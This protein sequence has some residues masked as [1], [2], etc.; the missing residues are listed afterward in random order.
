MLLTN[1]RVIVMTAGPTNTFIAGHLVPSSPTPITLRMDNRLSLRLY[2][3]CLPNFLEVAPLHK[4][5]VLMLDGKELIEEGMGFGV[6]VVKYRDK[7]FFSSSAK[8]YIEG[9][10][11]NCMLVKSFNLDTISRKRLWKTSFVNDEFYGFFQK[12]FQKA[13]LDHKSLSPIFNRIMELGKIMMVET[14][15]IKVKP[16]GTITLRYS[17]Q[18]GIIQIQ[19][20]LSELE[21][22]E[23]Q[24]ILILN[25]QG[26]SF[27]NRYLDT[28]GLSLLNEKIGAWEKVKAKEASLS[29]IEK[30]LEFT[31]RNRDQGFL[32]RGRENTK[33]RFS[34]AGLSYS[35]EPK[36]SLFDYSIRL[37]VTGQ[38]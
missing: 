24:E 5:L 4:G 26:A 25:E 35:L 8:C 14:E 6:P 33:N 21:L 23:C 17:C 28:D 34:W 1:A 9:I 29:D 2:T 16:R 22:D 15:F 13:Y 3:N 12:L 38:N 30:T 11:N 32:F 7:T 10:G 27:F 19:V 36:P 37:R 31:L 18:P 20:N